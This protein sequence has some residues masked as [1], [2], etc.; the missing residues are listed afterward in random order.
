LQ[1]VI[2]IAAEVARLEKEMTKCDADIARVDAKLNNPNFVSRAPEEVV[3]EEKE[4]REGALVRKA[5]IAEA[6]QRLRPEPNQ[7]FYDKAIR[8]LREL[9]EKAKAKQELHFVMALM[10][11]FRGVQDAGWNTGEEAIH[12]FDQFS[13]L[14]KKLDK[15]DPARVRVFL[16]FYMH[17]A[18]GAGFYEIPKKLLLTIEG[19]G[20]N[21]LPF[22]SLVKTH[23]E[24]G[25]RIAP[26]A[27]AIMRDLVG[28]A[29][30][31][32][33]GE[34]SEVF[35]DAFD[36]DVRNAIAHADYI[37]APDGMRLRRRNGGAV[38]IISWD[39]LDA[40]I[41]RGLNLFSFIRQIVDEYTRSYYPPK[42]IKSRLSDVEPITDYTLYY[43]PT[44]G[45][46]GWISGKEPPKG[47][48]QGA[49]R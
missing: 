3:E 1:G 22:Q 5:K 45:A 17:V 2:D 24:T 10:P 20:N 32:G 42:T 30:S 13:N 27:N 36:A 8:A 6:L 47:F 12:A 16:A 15:N 11:E 26:N 18:E 38:R 34:L 31:L 37:L 35:R 39:E 28:C 40:L 41:S 44:T 43:D 19:R 7:E 14:L 25:A 33:L 23:Q 46:F 9:F 48:N 4:K 21:I 29:D 49:G